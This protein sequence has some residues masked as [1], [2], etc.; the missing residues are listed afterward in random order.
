[1][2]VPNY[3]YKVS[4]YS[5]DS[6]LLLHI[7]WQDIKYTLWAKL[8]VLL[9]LQKVVDRMSTMLYRVTTPNWFWVV[10]LFLWDVSNLLPPH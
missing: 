3:I 9:K 2:S 4:S 8:S 1:M 6:T 10:G 5:T 7:I